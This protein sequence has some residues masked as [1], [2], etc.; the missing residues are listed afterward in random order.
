MQRITAEQ[1][2]EFDQLV[3]DT[4]RLCDRRNSK[5]SETIIKAKEI[6]EQTEDTRQLILVEYLQA[7]Y[8]CFIE[9]NYDRSIRHLNAAVNSM[10]SEDYAAVGYKLL[11]TLGNSYQLKGDLFSSQDSYLKGL[12]CLET[13]AALNPSE[14][15]FLAS[16][17]YNLSVLLSS[18]ELNIETEEYL[19]KAIAIYK[20]QDKKFPLSNCYVAY[21]Q[22]FE[23]KSDFPRAVE[24]LNAAL[25]LVQESNEPYSIA[26]S[27]ANLGLLLVKTGETEKSFAYL[28]SALSFFESNGML[29]EFGMVKFEL[30]QAYFFIHR[31]ERSLEN[32]S[33]AEA[34]MLRLDNKK[35]LSEIYKYKS[36]V[37]AA[38]GNHMK[39]YEYQEKYIECLK[40]FFDNEK[41]NAL[42]RTKNEF[43]TELKEKESQL[44][45]EK[46]EEIQQY[47]QKLEVS[48]NE[49]KQFAHVASHDLREPLRMIT[50]Y[51]N[52]LGKSMSERI[53]EQESEFFGF[54]QDGAKRMDQLIQDLLRLAKVDANPIIAKLKLSN[55]I[56]E[57]KLNLEALINEKSAVIKL[58]TLPV[59][60]ADR[61]QMLQ[62][63][64]NLIANGIKYNKSE[65]PLIHISSTRRKN[66]VE[67]T[68]TDNGIGI[69]RHLRE[70][71]F[72]IFRRLHKQSDTSGSGIGLAICKKIVE[73]MGGKIKIEDAED[74]GTI[75]RIIL[76]ADLVQA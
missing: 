26:L 13:K 28:N 59:I 12:K 68:V 52:L 72:Q 39:A 64:Q 48:N 8:D 44:L 67:I 54:V 25:L 27:K 1:I 2:R 34:I 9:N 51:I 73:S 16:F 76:P 74:S 69:P 53:N 7:Y 50:A 61:S 30:G 37:L 70:E 19:E 47:V 11:M 41:T 31:S 57:I 42:T 36:R 33:E 4:E 20:K 23:R 58:D 65:V 22:L 17:Y 35:E 32:I 29:F 15:T 14:E 49:L 38:M 21:A 10:N 6:A 5:A 24:Y 3:I 45:R 60:M 63:F 62:L 46:N 75:F 55:L 40:F 43:E 56:E 71:A 18:S 66:T